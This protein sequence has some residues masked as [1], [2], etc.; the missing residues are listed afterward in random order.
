MPL[1]VPLARL[2]KEAARTTRG[3]VMVGR[4][5]FLPGNGTGRRRRRIEEEELV[6]EA[7][8]CPWLL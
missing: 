6:E 1:H 4:G 7:W 2:R 8:T 5:G 3:V